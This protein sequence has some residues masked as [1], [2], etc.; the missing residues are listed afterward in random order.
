MKKEME[1][2]ETGSDHGA[3]AIKKRSD[4]IRIATE[5]QKIAFTEIT[6][7]VSNINIMTQSNASSSEEW[8]GAP[9]KYQAW[10]RR[11]EGKWI[12]SRPDGLFLLPAPAFRVHLLEGKPLGRVRG[13]PWQGSI[14]ITTGTSSTSI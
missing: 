6:K 8:R 10:R 5:E 7:S 12:F 4:E 2:N 9:R 3:D 11:C 13:D 14:T 1:L